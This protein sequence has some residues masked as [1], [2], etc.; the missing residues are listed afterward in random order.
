MFVGVRF[1]VGRRS[2]EPR[3]RIGRVSYGTETGGVHNL[4]RVDP[5]ARAPR[6]DERDRAGQ[7]VQPRDCA[8]QG[9]RRQPEESAGGGHAVDLR[10]RERPCAKVLRKLDASMLRCGVMSH[11]PRVSG[12]P[13]TEGKNGSEKRA[14]L[15]NVQ[16]SNSSR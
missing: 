2:G 13:C 4:L 12:H 16:G 14:G 10:V 9:P 1:V 11:T 3:E 15:P 5:N 6:L 7:N 8:A